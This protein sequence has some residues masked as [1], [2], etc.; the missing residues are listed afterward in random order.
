MRLTLRIS[1]AVAG[2]D[3]GWTGYA[4]AG[5]G[6]RSDNDPLLLSFGPQTGDGPVLIAWA[7]DAIDPAASLPDAR[8][9]LLL[10]FLDIAADHEEE[11]NAWY[12]SEHLPRLREVPGVTR[13]ERYCASDGSPRYLAMFELTN[14]RVAE[15][16]QWLTAGRT[17]WTARMKRQ[18]LG[19]RSFMFTPP[20]AG[21]V[22][23]S[24]P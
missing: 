12:D 16:P 19:Y 5:G 7:G 9:I 21:D 10:N 11:F 2:Q 14:A 22:I 1:R 20:G 18:T 23:S 8:A 6:G 17:P 3:S 4:R 13:A 24:G 15:G